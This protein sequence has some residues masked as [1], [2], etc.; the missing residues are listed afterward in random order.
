MIKFTLPITPQTM[1]SESR[2]GVIKT[3][4]GKQ[5]GMIFSSSKKKGYLFEITMAARQYAPPEPFLG[6]VHLEM[7]FVLPRPKYAM[8]KSYDD[9]LIWAPVHPDEDNLS[10]AAVDGLSGAGFWKNDAQIVRKK[11]RKVFAEKTG[12]PRF[13]IVIEEFG[14]PLI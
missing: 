13:E 2:I 8:A 4:T 6:P 1:Q 12:M 11:I 9:G 7:L 14:G 3:K 5:R 10:K